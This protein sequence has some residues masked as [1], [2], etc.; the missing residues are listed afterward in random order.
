MAS[1]VKT[2]P[3]L[4]RARY[5]RLWPDGEMAVMKAG[6]AYEDAREEMSREDPDVEMLEVEITVLRSHGRPQLNAVTSRCV[7]CPTCGENIY[8]EETTDG[9]LIT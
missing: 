3:P 4:S 9:E 5:A 1:D 2:T 6:L 8:V 7:H